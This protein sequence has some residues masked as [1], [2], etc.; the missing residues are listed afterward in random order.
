MVDKNVQGVIK[1]LFGLQVKQLF[2]LQKEVRL[3]NGRAK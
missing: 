1:H 3:A 2:G